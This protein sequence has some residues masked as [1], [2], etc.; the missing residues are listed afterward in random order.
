MLRTRGRI[1]G[2]TNAEIESLTPMS[3]IHIKSRTFL[4]K[5]LLQS[6]HAVFIGGVRSSRWL[7]S[8]SKANDI[9]KLMA[10]DL[11]TH[12]QPQTTNQ[13]ECKQLRRALEAKP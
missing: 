5:G 1:G 2:Q 10:K 3:D 4:A 9:A 11:F 7:D 6:R 12:K 8:W 13:Y